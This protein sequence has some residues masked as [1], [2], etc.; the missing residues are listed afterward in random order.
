MERLFCD[1]YFTY[2]Q[3]ERNITAAP[4]EQKILRALKNRLVPKDTGGPHSKEF[5]TGYDFICF[6]DHVAHLLCCIVYVCTTLALTIR[7]KFFVMP[8]NMHESF[9]FHI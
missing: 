9:I 3:E 5:P 8:I 1:V 6:D 7:Y 4:M 2:T